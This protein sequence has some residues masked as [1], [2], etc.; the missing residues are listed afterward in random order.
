MSRR[1]AVDGAPDAEDQLLRQRD[2]NSNL[3]RQLHDHEQTIRRC[4]VQSQRMQP[5]LVVVNGR[6]EQGY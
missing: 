5:L 3:K 6:S 2:E 1:A 4:V